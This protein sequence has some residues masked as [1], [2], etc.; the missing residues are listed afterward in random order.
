MD[1]PSAPFIII[2]GDKGAFF[3][4]RTF[5][6]DARWKHFHA[7]N[8]FRCLRPSVR[9]IIAAASSSD[10]INWRYYHTQTAHARSAL[11]E[12]WENKI[13]TPRAQQQH[14]TFDS[15]LMEAGRYYNIKIHSLFTPLSYN[16]NIITICLP[17][18][19]LCIKHHQQELLQTLLCVCD[20]NL[21]KKTSGSDW[22]GKVVSWGQIDISW[23]HTGVKWKW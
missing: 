3:Q 11:R 17:P 13:R 20:T 6:G 15:W 14:K 18:P 21:K 16:K 12:E 10:I 22:S 5:V 7:W 2:Y 4:L 9:H 1:F 8:I 23:E 19:V